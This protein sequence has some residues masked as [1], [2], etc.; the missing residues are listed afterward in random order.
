MAS[1]HS[2]LESGRLTEAGCGSER[3]GFSSEHEARTAVQRLALDQLA[4]YHRQPRELIS[5]ANRE[6][7]AVEGYRGRQLLELLQNAD[8]AANGNDDEH[9]LLIEV[10]AGCLIAANTGIPFSLRGLESLVISDCSPK[11]LDR[12]RFIGCKGLRFR[13][14]LT[15]TNRPLISSGAL[16]VAF[17][18]DRALQAIRDV[19]SDNLDAAQ[20]IEEFTTAEGHPPVPIMRFPYIP[21]TDSSELQ[22]ANEYRERGYDTVVVL[23]L[24]S[25]S[26]P[27]EVELQVNSLPTESLLFCRY[28]TEVRLNCIHNRRWEILREELSPERMRLIMQG[29]EGDNLWTIHRRELTLSAS[30]N[31]AE[32][33]RRREFQTAVAVPDEPQPAEDRT[34]CV[35]FP[36]HDSLPLPVMLHATLVL[37][38]GRNRILDTVANRAVLAALGEHLVE[39]VAGEA[40]ASSPKRALRLLDG[41]QHADPELKRLGFVDSVVEHAR[42]RAIFPRIDGS[43]GSARGA[44]KTPHDSWRPLLL[45]KHFPEVLDIR[46]DDKLGALLQFFDV[47]WFEQEHLVE[48][49]EAQLADIAPVEAGRIV[50]R[51]I[52][53]D[54]LGRIPVGTFIVDSAG[55][56]LRDGA[57][58]FFTPSAMLAGLPDW[59]DDIRFMHAEFQDG[60]QDGASPST[61]RGLSGLLEKRNANIDEYRLDTVIRALITRVN[62]VEDDAKPRRVR[63]LL[64]WLFDVS[65]GSPPALAQVLIPILDHNGAVARPSDCYLGAEYPGGRLL[66]RLYC[67]VPAVRFVASPHNLGVGDVPVDRAQA[68]LT[69]IGVRSVPRLTELRREHLRE[70]T[71]RLIEQLE[72]PTTVRTK[73][74]SNASD[75]RALCRE[76]TVDE[77]L[78]PDALVE[79]IERADPTVLVAFLSTDGATFVASHLDERACFVARTA[80][81]RKPWRDPS[82]PIP[83]PVIHFLHTLRWVPGDDGQRHRPSEITLS[84]AASRILKGLYFRHTLNTDDPAIQKA[85]GRRAVNGLL[86]RLGAIASLESI[87]SE[88]LY[89]LL[90][91]LPEH[92]PQGK[93][94]PGIYRTLVDANVMPDDCRLRRRFL[95][96]GLIWS[97]YGGRSQYLPPA[98]VRYNANVTI[99]PLVEEH[100]KVAELPR[101]KGSKLVHALFGVRALTPAD[102]DLQLV[103]EGTEYDPTSEDANARFQLAVP[104]IYA[105]RLAKRLDEDNK[106][107]NLLARAELRLCRRIAVSARLPDGSSKS[108]ELSARG[109]SILLRS[110]LLVV[111]EYHRDAPTLVRFWHS[112]AN[113][114]AELLGTDIAAEVANVLRCRNI[115]EMEDAVCGQIGAD[116]QEKMAEARARIS[117]TEEPEP[118]EIHTVPEPA[119]DR[120]DDTND[121]SGETQGGDGELATGAGVLTGAAGPPASA[122][123]EPISGPSGSRAR[124]RRLVLTPRA[125][126]ARGGGRGPIATEDVTF[127][128]VEAYEEAA[129]PKRFPL[130]VSHIHGEEGFGCDILSLGSEEVRQRARESGE[131]ADSDIVRFIEVKGRSARS[132]QVELTDNEYEKAEVKR[133]RYFIYRVFRDPDHPD[134]FELAVLQD[135]ANSKAVRH[136]TR[137]DLA[138][139]SG[140][141]WFSMVAADGET[142]SEMSGGL[143]ESSIDS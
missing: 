25:G 123:F 40:T 15:W 87:D 11:Q 141:E 115:F 22:L 130:R 7:S 129:E 33:G 3:V 52:S 73:R 122:T 119:P 100:I 80:R 66:S 65:D 74:C 10:R 24:K 47:S 140:A 121:T 12:N 84:P 4:V 126:G 110:T 139:G 45:P 90:L 83:N 1:V 61:M 8:D 82:I 81:E 97:R 127:R 72:Y 107:R 96:R 89:D 136:V 88:T 14:V 16:Q 109:D 77:L 58:C 135:P 98:E 49:L 143:S 138:E 99:P 23:P 37:G 133:E 53:N 142:G 42:D 48:R 132:G 86:T 76:Y 50:G 95:E 117:R 78:V 106:E 56:F 113:L 102:I 44:V 60:L 38:D 28:L 125:G 63:E 92:D 124:K 68:F 120:G 34:L 46:T 5:H 26:V 116:A 118:D 18:R 57:H 134:R 94:A 19:L 108:I 51:L 31:T 55:K 128:I 32:A 9:R 43:L 104:Y 70:F 131:V 30:E 59:A 85:G 27:E 91:R 36:T 101:R 35:F 39:V 137:F 41:L 105:L 64:R 62:Q 20:I 6:N 71:E 79:L 93:H 67:D 111:D 112:V 69:S 114:V 2:K 54:R 75:V 21:D 13:S 29:A 17:C 103:H